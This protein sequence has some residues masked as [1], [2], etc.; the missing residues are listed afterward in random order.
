MHHHSGNEVVKQTAVIS[1]ALAQCRFHLKPF[2]D[3]GPDTDHGDGVARLVFDQRG[4]QIEDE[5]RTIGPVVDHLASPSPLPQ[6]GVDDFLLGRIGL[7]AFTIDRDMLANPGG[8]GQFQRLGFRPVDVG[9]DAVQIG[10]GDMILELIEHQRLETELSLVLLALG[11]VIDNDDEVFG[12]RTKDLNRKPL[13][14]GLDRELE[15]FRWATGGHA[16]VDLEQPGI[17]LTDAGND[18]GDAL[19]TDL[20]QSG[21]HMESGVG[22]E[23]DVVGW[24]AL[25]EQH[26]THG[27]AVGHEIQHL[28]AQ[29]A[30]H[31][32]LTID[33]R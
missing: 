5:G 26:P 16:P 19:A 4:A 11:D 25:L 27:D 31:R 8:G 12:L 29:V 17:R 13:V 33:Q 21:L 6:R 30:G 24:N 23:M 22:V 28:G 18:L 20:A 14:E 3:I 1:L 10:D 15:A 2:A 32:R 7:G 9:H